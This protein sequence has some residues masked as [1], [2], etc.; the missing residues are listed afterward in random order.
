MVVRTSRIWSVCLAASLCAAQGCSP[1]DGDPG[2]GGDGAGNG[3][4]GGD[5]GAGDDGA[6]GDGGAPAGDGTYKVEWGPVMVDPGVEA[7]LC[8][9]KRL[10][11]DRPIKVGQFINQLGPASHHMI[12]YRLAEGEETTEPEECL[13]FVDVL[14]PTKG[15]PL[16]V[17]QKTE[18]TISLPP[19]VGVSLQAGQLVRLELHFINATDH[20]Q[21]LSASS[22][23]VEIPEAE[24]EQE[25]DFLFIGNPDIEIGP[26]ETF[27]LGPSY[28]PMPANLAGINIFAVTGHEHQWGTDVQASL[29]TGPDDPGT[30]IYAPENFQWSEPETVYHDPAVTMPDGGGFRFTCSWHNGT[31]QTVRFGESVNDEMCFFWAYYY[32]S[33][34]AKICFHTEQFGGEDGLDLCCPDSNLCQLVDEF[35]RNN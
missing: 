14:D 17:T 26:G 3:G 29:A 16:A 2:D 1:D 33:Q 21:E 7:T 9:R 24:F 35:L 25:A 27:T 20:P 5:G 15:A 34:G 28:L 11:T 30:A 18:E 31:E 13:P 32:P 4:G 8:V 23:F 22:T 19:G 6:G 12:V 10:P